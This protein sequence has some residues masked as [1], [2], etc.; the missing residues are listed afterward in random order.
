MRIL[1][2][3]MFVGKYTETLEYTNKQVILFKKSTA[4]TGK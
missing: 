1:E 2:S 3:E 4:F